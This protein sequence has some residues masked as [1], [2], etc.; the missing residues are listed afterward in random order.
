MAY[1]F[2]R[3]PG[4]REKLTDFFVASSCHRKRSAEVGCPCIK[5]DDAAALRCAEA[6][7]GRASVA[8]GTTK[9]PVARAYLKHY[10]YKIANNAIDPA[11]VPAVV[12]V[13]IELDHGSL[14]A[15]QRAAPDMIDSYAI[16]AQPALNSRHTVGKT[17]DMTIAW[18]GTL[19]LI[20][21]ANA[22]NIFRIKSAEKLHDQIR[23]PPGEAINQNKLDPYVETQTLR[24]QNALPTRGRVTVFNPYCSAVGSRVM[25]IEIAGNELTRA[26]SPPPTQCTNAA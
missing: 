15:S 23:F 22:P 26:L 5:Y 9:R 21:C 12:G 8:I 7:S 4:I 16:V 2:H 18:S 10:A 1:L 13:D 20:R 14:E 17:I 11:N 19:I 3:E 25:R 6:V 24:C